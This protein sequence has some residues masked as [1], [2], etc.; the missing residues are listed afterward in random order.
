MSGASSDTSAGLRVGY[1]LTHYPR[2]AQTFIA[3]EITAVE[4]TGVTVLPFAMN[5]P[6]ASEQAAPGAAE[7]VARTTYLK[8][9]MVR[10]LITLAGQMLR[11]PLG[12][13]RVMTMALASAGAS[14]GRIVRRLA[15]LLQAALV[16]QEAGRERLDYLHAQFGLAP[17]TIAWLAAALSSAAGRRLPFGFTIHGFHDFVEPAESRLDLKARD[18]AQVLCISDYTRSQLCLVTDPALWPRFHVARCGIDLSAFRYRSPPD[19]DR[20]PTVLAV[21]RLSAEK[22]FDILIE[23]L[24]QL[25]RVG[26]PQRLVLVG[27]GPLR[28]SLES[29]ASGSGVADLIEFAGELPPADVRAHLERADLFC[30]PSFSEG[31]PISIMEAMA[32]GVPVVTT[33]IAGI[34][35]LAE[36]GVTALTVPPA[37]PDTL[38]Q[39][40]QQLAEDGQ[41]RL[42]LSQAARSKVEAQ[43]DQS[44]CGEIVA[45]HFASAASR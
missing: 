16:A 32:V 21:G 11:H 5:P 31:L 9:Q 6:T 15:H 29:A 43:H 12:V 18:A 19:H 10:A 27:D 33:W 2:L 1:V 38:A 44:R 30:L 45:R 20:M 36:S 3:A 24:A 25:K 42:R 40:M 28:T 13:G 23:A 14:P 26:A 4:R 34:P 7:R 22:G 41:L 8:P 35:E 37:R 39:A 17:A